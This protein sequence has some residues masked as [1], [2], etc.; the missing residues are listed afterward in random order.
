MSISTR[1]LVR[2]ERADL[3]SFLET[4]TPA[5]W[6]A[7]SLCDKWRVRDVV[8]HVVAYDTFAPSIGW[9]FLRA[10]FSVDR[11]NLRIADASRKRTIDELLARL[12]ANLIPGG[13]TRLI[14]WPVALQEA[15]VHHQDVRRP[16][17]RA[18]E[19]PSER[20]V[21]VLECLIDPPFLAA[22]PKRATGLRLEATDIG[23]QWGDGPVVTGTGEAI[24]L[25]LAGRASV[26][27][28]LSGTG[29]S[30]LQVRM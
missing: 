23:W 18:R 13:I 29:V 19:I 4:L 21:G 24:M 2:Q 6:D 17:R 11:L 16:L 12:R 27:D 20:V 25:A 15:V 7:D 3:V 22:L 14:G 5:D 30:T 8:A 1:E 26:L 10:A 9:H 28:E